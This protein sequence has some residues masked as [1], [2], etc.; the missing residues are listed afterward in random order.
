MGLREREE[1]EKTKVLDLSYWKA[2]VTVHWDGE[3]W[4]RN[5]SEKGDEGLAF[6]YVLNTCY[7][8]K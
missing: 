1:S 7:T 5:K 6:C 8:F 4:E 3:E 2:V